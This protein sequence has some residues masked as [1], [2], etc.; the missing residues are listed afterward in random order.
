M[1]TQSVDHE[2]TKETIESIVIALI[3]AFVF[4]AFIVEAFVIPTGSMAPTLNGAHGTILCEDCGSG[5]AYGLRDPSDSRRGNIVSANARARCPNCGHPNSNLVR[6]DQAQNPERGDRIL[7]LKWPLETGIEALGPA[8]WDVV[9]FKDPSDGETNFI[10]RLVGLPEEVLVILDGDVFTAP[11][12]ELSDETIAEL[13]GLRHQKFELRRRKRAGHL[14]SPSEKVWK[15]LGE[16]LSVAPKTATAQA[17]LWFPVYNHDFPPA[18]NQ[19]FQPRWTAARGEASGWHAKSTRMVFRDRQTREDYIVL[20]GKQITA[21]NA[22]SIYTGPAPPVGDHRV[23]FVL[24]PESNQGEV[25][26][27]LAK[28]GRDFWATIRFDGTV[29]LVRSRRNSPDE[30]TPAMTSHQLPS[31]SV[32]KPIAITFENVDYRLALYIDGKEVLSSSSDPA[33]PSYYGPKI[34][35]LRRQKRV[36]PAKPPRVYGAGGDFTIAH[37]NIERDVYY[38]NHRNFSIP[39]APDGGW[40]CAESPIMLR[41]DEFFML[42]D[43]TAASKDSRLWD[44][45]D[46]RIDIR[47]EA[48]QLGTVPRD[49]LIGKAFFVYWPSP[50]KVGWLSWLPKLRGE[51][52][53]DVGNMRWIR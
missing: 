49:Q 13:D 27:C 7:V 15:E 23:G 32:G 16:K 45:V 8:R 36:P 33:D 28:L 34:N 52:V 14:R 6:N 37:L 43:N 40:G 47:D 3:L 19:S 41:T 39:W 29:A 25:Q 42:G 24:T 17:S 48:F 35:A 44:R 2:G 5:F 12:S 4:R 30:S 38:Y 10:K 50:L 22:Y 51:I 18:S 1:P 26:I 9:V 31:F 53:P 11:L 46:E 20:A 21:V